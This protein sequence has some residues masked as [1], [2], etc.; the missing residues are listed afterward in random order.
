MSLRA[1]LPL[2][3]GLWAG[4]GSVPRREPP[5]EAAG[6]EIHQGP[7]PLAL[8]GGWLAQ[9]GTEGLVLTSLSGAPGLTLALD[10][11]LGVGR[12][13]DGAL[14]VL[15]R[16]ALRPD[17]TRLSVLRRGATSAEVYTGEVHRSPSPR[18][19]LLAGRGPDELLL[20]ARGG[21]GEL[22]RI[23]L[24]DAQLVES[25]TVQFQGD[26]LRAATSLPGGEVIL[27][28]APG[29]VR[30]GLDGERSSVSL[31]EGAAW[32][33]HLAAGGANQV[34]AGV[35]G[36]SVAL[37]DADGALIAA[38]RSVDGVLVDLAADDRQAYALVGR[39]DGGPIRWRV[40]AYNAQGEVWSHPLDCAAPSAGS[41]V[42]GEGEVAV[43][44]CLKLSRFTADG[45]A[46]GGE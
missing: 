2:S 11:P 7:D 18:L 32:L 17:Q 20:A 24:M 37:L 30:V 28:G 5:V 34:W 10:E 14:A 4:C 35:A 9:I 33:T 42:A 15:D 21:P 6:P 3:L 25:G 40:A 12:L 29:W 44:V 36:G 1:A 13:S 45:S 41:V 16:P 23:Q 27:A 8:G 43:W 19:T 26:E 39:Y 22:T 31:P 46:S 38:P